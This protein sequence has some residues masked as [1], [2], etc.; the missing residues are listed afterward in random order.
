MNLSQKQLDILAANA[1]TIT[2]IATMF[3]DEVAQRMRDLAGQ[4][5]TVFVT[6]TET[7]SER[8]ERIARLVEQL[9]AHPGETRKFYQQML[10]VCESAMSNYFSEVRVR[11]K[12][13]LRRERD[14]S[15]GLTF[16]S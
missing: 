13:C 12:G 2:G 5:P 16:R 6:P 7:T 9:K 3:E 8:E 4:S 11:Y 10:G 1:F 15:N 14:R